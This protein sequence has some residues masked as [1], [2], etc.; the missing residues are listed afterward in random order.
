MV[1]FAT[2]S[3]ESAK[4]NRIILK[5][6]SIVGVSGLGSR[7]WSVMTEDELRETQRKVARGE[8]GEKQLHYR[9]Y[10]KHQPYVVEEVWDGI[11][12][13]F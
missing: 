11:F 12:R 10:A 9:I 8:A 5:N 3:I 4:A 1:G 2:G 7:K 6:C 13:I